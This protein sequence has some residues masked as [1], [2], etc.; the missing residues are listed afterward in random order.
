VLL[1]VNHILVWMGCTIYNMFMLC[2][3]CVMIIIVV[4][5]DMHG[6]LFIRPWVPTQ[7][8]NIPI[9]LTSP[10]DYIKVI[11]MQD[12]CP[13]GQLSYKSI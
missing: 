13:L 10:M 11:F 5:I 6:I 4:G 7:P 2:F 8:I 1:K 12:K 3:G 9:N